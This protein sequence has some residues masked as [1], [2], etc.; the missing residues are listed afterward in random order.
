MMLSPSTN[1]RS[2][3]HRMCIS[4]VIR[5]FGIIVFIAVITL[6]FCRPSLSVTFL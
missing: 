2:I 4:H 6:A 3:L 5:K 1:V